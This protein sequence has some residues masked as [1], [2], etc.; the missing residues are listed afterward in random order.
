MGIPTFLRSSM[1][2]LSSIV[3]NNVAGNFGD[4]A[5]AAVSV[6]NKCTRFVSA[7]IMGFG[8]GFQ[9][10]AGYCWGARKYARVRKSFKFSN[11]IG[12]SMGIVLGGIMVLLVKDLVGIFT[13]SNDQDIIQ[14]GSFM[15]ITQCATLLPHVFGTISNGLFQ[16]LGKATAAA[17]LGMSRQVI[18]LIPCVV[19]LSS[20]FGI[21][22]LAS[23]QAAADILTLLIALP[24]TIK[25]F[26]EIKRLEARQSAEEQQ[27]SLK[28]ETKDIDI[29]FCME[30]KLQKAG[31]EN[32]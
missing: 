26:S 5:I 32:E 31:V 19:I 27:Q 21:Y 28:A 16:A 11:I 15:I 25:L 4:T 8:L 9:T 29:E 30:L 22:G 2:S 13:V 18:F 24:M 17:V 14:I 10:V 20:V 7:T 6:A 1:L 12:G 23:A 3:T